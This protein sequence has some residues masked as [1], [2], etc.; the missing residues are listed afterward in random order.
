[1]R[2]RRDSPRTQKP[3]TL[4]TTEHAA[5]S[6]PTARPPTAKTH[7]ATHA[8]GGPMSH[9][10]RA[11][12]FIHGVDTRWDD[13]NTVAAAPIYGK[14]GN[15]HENQFFWTAT[16]TGSAKFRQGCQGVTFV[17][18]EAVYTICCTS[19]KRGRIQHRALRG[20][21]SGRCRRAASR[22]TAVPCAGVH[23]PTERLVPEQ[24]G[25][26]MMNNT[27]ILRRIA[28]RVERDHASIHRGTR[29]PRRGGS[30]FLAMRLFM[31]NPPLPTQ[32]PPATR[33]A[34]PSRS[35]RTSTYRR[36]PCRTSSA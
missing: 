20:T 18:G 30:G 1:M 31:I 29:R 9:P 23:S 34:F 26:R 4:S 14:D 36:R 27:E 8:P 2:C 33:G 11:K 35:G 5:I 28:V 22:R 16:P 12:Y 7:G 25:V 17:P 15:A 6:G 24:L 3:A 19:V 21:P 10:L 13:K 32:Q